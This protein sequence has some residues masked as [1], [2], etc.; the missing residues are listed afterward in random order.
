MHWTAYA[1]PIAPYNSPLLAQF[2]FTF[3]AYN[4]ITSFQMA[5]SALLDMW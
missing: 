1:L 5:T 2:H 3:Q 4:P